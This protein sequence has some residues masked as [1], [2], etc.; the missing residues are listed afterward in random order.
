MVEFRRILSKTHKKSTHFDK[1]SSHCHASSLP[2]KRKLKP[3]RKHEIRASVV[4][5]RTFHIGQKRKSKYAQPKEQM[6]CPDEQIRSRL[7]R[8]YGQLRVKEN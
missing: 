8:Q 2:V 6:Y 1:H 7:C 5:T 4:I 3:S